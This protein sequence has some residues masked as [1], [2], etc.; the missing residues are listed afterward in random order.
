MS[1]KLLIEK[2]LP[3]RFKAECLR[4]AFKKKKCFYIVTS[5]YECS[6]MSTQSVTSV[7]VCVA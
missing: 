6:G 3:F 2:V 5:L 1:K 4:L 7:I